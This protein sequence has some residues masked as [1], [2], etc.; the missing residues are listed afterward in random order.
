M[1][2]TK[3]TGA[4]LNNLKPKED[5]SRVTYWDGSFRGL[6]L[7]VGRR[8]KTWSYYYRFNGKLRNHRLGKYA[9]GRVDHM[10][11]DAARKAADAVAKLVEQGVDPKTRK[12]AVEPKP[13]IKNPNTLKRRVKQYLDLY[14]AQ[15]KPSTFAQGERLLT[16]P[17]LAD[18]EQTSVKRITRGEVVELLEGMAATPVQANRLHSYLAKF[19]KWCW[20]HGYCEPSPMVG[21]G[22][23][24]KE[25]SRRRHLNR[26]E[27]KALWN[28][29]IELGYPLGDWCLFTLATGQRPGECRKLSRDDIHKGVWLVEG[30]DPKNE[31]RHRIPLP[32]IAR[33]ILKAAPE[34]EGAFIF[35]TTNGKKPLSQGGKPYGF[36][37]EAVGLD[38]PWRPHDLRRTFQTIASEELDIEPHLIGAICN[39]TSVAKP[40]VSSV[41]NQAKWM[42]QKERALEAWND[43]LLEAVK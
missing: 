5:G 10:D 3:F 34:H 28:G 26:E 1:P 32:K 24:F 37:Y 42:P 20:N 41:Y 14:K 15:V 39:Q 33:D 13:T 9:K 25:K 27:I 29:C 43:W 30:G 11:I 18:F 40:G 8:D 38:E 17:Y 19:F 2:V 7:R 21:L 22:K 16:G 31:Q 4:V 12:I 6:C 23:P 35:S 36:L